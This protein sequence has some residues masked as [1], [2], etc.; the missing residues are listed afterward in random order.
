VTLSDKL[1]AGGGR[2]HQGSVILLSGDVHHSF[3]A[4]LKYRATK[5]FEDT[6]AQST[7]VV[8]VE[9][10]ASSFKKQDGKTVILHKEGFTGAPPGAHEFIP[11]HTPEGY[12]GYNLPAGTAVAQHFEFGSVMGAAGGVWKDIKLEQGAPLGVPTVA[13]GHEREKPAHLFDPKEVR[14]VKMPPDFRYRL[15]YLEAATQGQQPLAPPTIAPFPPTMSRA[16][17]I[18]QFNRATNFYR[19]YNYKGFSKQQIVGLNNIGE[20]T[21][22]RSTAAIG[23]VNHTIRWKPEESADFQWATWHV[24]VAPEDDVI[25]KDIKA[26]NE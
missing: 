25:Y 13:L 18:K 8:F 4:R 23:F 6:T 2:T 22:E 14:L 10:V 20:I 11:P 1:P 24:Y 17:A 12:V 3:A 9:L 5:R 15:D 7:S 16:D 26:E 19:D 21:F